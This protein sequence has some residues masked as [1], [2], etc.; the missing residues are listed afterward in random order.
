MKLRITCVSHRSRSWNVT[1]DDGRNFSVVA[2]D[3]LNDP[4][5]VRK[6]VKE[7]KNDVVHGECYWL[8]PERTVPMV[9][10]LSSPKGSES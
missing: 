5:I 9:S 10:L 1:L 4:K 6:W 8:K 3:S 2:W 7:N